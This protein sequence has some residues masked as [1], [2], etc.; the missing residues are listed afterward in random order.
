M[1]RKLTDAFIID[2][3]YRFQFDH[4][5]ATE[6]VEVVEVVP[7]CWVFVKECSKRASNFG[8]LINLNNVARVFGHNFN[9]G[10]VEAR[11]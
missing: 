5:F 6:W 4:L 9:K 1:E 11:G 2:G 10:D 7:P 8:E 3:Q